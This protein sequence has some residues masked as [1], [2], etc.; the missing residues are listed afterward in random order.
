MEPYLYLLAQSFVGHV[1]TGVDFLLFCNDSAR[2][3]QLVFGN[4]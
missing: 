4:K 2:F 3:L 1:Q